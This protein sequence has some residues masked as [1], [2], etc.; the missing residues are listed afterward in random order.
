MTIPGWVLLLFAAWTVVL[1]SGT[2]GYFRWSRILTGRATIREWRPDEDQG[3]DWYRRAMRA[4]ANFLEN[5]PLY[6]AVVIALL[7]AKASSPWLD[8]LEVQF[9]SIGIPSGYAASSHRR[10]IAFFTTPYGFLRP[11]S[12]G[13]YVAPYHRL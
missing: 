13:E 2:V 10:F 1:L 6:T 12:R 3:T 5:L 7:V 8:A 9:S 4:H 11:Q